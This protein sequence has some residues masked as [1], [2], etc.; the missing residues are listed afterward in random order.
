[1][2]ACGTAHFWGSRYSRRRAPCHAAAPAIRA[3][4]RAPAEDGSFG[5]GRAARR[6]AERRLPRVPVKSVA[7]QELQALHRFASSGCRHGLL[8]STPCA[9]YGVS[10]ALSSVRV[11]V[12]LLRKRSG[13]SGP[14]MQP[15]LEGSAG[16]FRELIAEIADLENALRRSSA[17]CEGSPRTRR[18]DTHA[19]GRDDQGALLG[20]DEGVGGRRGRNHG[21]RPC[22]TPASNTRDRGRTMSR[23]RRADGLQQSSHFGGALG[24]SCT[25]SVS[26]IA[27]AAER[28]QRSSTTADRDSSN[29]G[30]V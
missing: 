5:C 24:A 18:R 25:P 9:V 15:F 20:C 7:Q 2:E 4:I 10:S 11:P 16:A 6:G 21:G 13:C 19:D 17:S 22:D 29:P 8:E 23:S 14:P 26:V 1:M 30:E 12:V 3:S 28:P 27:R